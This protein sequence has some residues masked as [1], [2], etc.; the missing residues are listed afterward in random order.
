MRKSTIIATCL[1]NSGMLDEL[2]AA[3]TS[4]ANIFAEQF[5]S[6]N[7]SQWNTEIPD[8]VAQHIISSVGRAKRINV[9]KFISDLM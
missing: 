8:N 2:V 3:E 9:G 7:L 5:P 4:V 6:E 1:I